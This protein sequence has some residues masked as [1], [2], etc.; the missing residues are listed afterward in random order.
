MSFT[1]TGG[2]PAHGSLSGSGAGR[3]YTPAN[4]FLGIDTFTFQM[5][6]AYRTSNTATVTIHVNPVNTAP[7]ANNDSYSVNENRGSDP[8]LVGFWPFN[9]GTG[10]TAFD[11]SGYGNHG[12][13]VN[14]PASSNDIPSAG[15]RTSLDFNG[16]NQAINV[17]TSASLQTLTSGLTLSAWVKIG[18][19]TL[20]FQ[21]HG[22]ISMPRDPGGTGWALRIENSALNL[23]ISD[24][25]YGCSFGGLLPPLPANTWTHLAATFEAGKRVKLYR[26]GTLV[27]SVDIS[28]PSFPECGTSFPGNLAVSTQPLHIGREFDD[29]TGYPRYFDGLIDEARVYSRALSDSEI[30]A[31]VN[32]YPLAVTAPGVLANDSDPDG[33]ITAILETAP[34]HGTLQFNADGS[35]TYAPTF[36]FSGTDSFTYRAFDGQLQ[37]S[38]AAVTLTVNPDQSVLG[39]VGGTGGATPYLVQCGPSAYAIGFRTRYDG[40]SG[41]YDYALTAADLMCSDSADA[42]IKG[43]VVALNDELKCGPADR[44]VGFFGYTNN[45]F[46]PNPNMAGVGARCQPSGGGSITN[47]GTAPTTGTPFGPYR[48]PVGTGRHRRVRTHRCRDRQPGSD[49]RREAVSETAGTYFRRRRAS[50]TSGSAAASPRIFR[51]AS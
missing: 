37:S 32:D 43:L 21:T 39:P 15:A 18:S 40:G 17:P 50:C 34:S 36:G 8:D 22:I 5:V 44:M 28:T 29:A 51:N 41:P 30:A 26:D 35:F 9:E 13:L 38:P 45:A 31:L 24:G 10:S 20:D 47:T 27:E 14:G 23:G 48:L 46:G 12:T 16:S 11:L 4:G 49:L 3:T 19:G 33:P 42:N 2:G 7:T 25:S 6:T 1:I